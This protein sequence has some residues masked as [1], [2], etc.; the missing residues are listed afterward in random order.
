MSQ[1]IERFMCPVCKST[2]V[3][4]DSTNETV[5]CNICGYK[6]SARTQ[7]LT[8]DATSSAS[9]V[10]GTLTSKPV[11]KTEEVGY[12]RTTQEIFLHSHEEFRT[13]E[14]DIEELKN[15]VKKLDAKVEDIRD[16]FPKVVVV[17]EVPKEEA[18]KRVEEYFKKHEMADIEELM[19]NL[20]IPVQTLVE[21][22]D[23]LK[24]EGK[25][26]AGDEQET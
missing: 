7:H 14:R 3:T 4:Y 15:S 9:I 16:I 22:I 18:R 12:R 21:I 6:F 23:E 8:Q 2:N 1:N 13:I 20:K 24:R 25:V 26:T 11:V 10:A 19:L 17:E 5:T